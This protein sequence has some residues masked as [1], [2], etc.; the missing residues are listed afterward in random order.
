M[1]EKEPEN[2]LNRIRLALER[3]KASL[4][5]QGFFDDEYIGEF[6]QT[7]ETRT[8][9][10]LKDQY[11]VSLAEFGMLKMAA[12]EAEEMIRLNTQDNLGVRFTL[13]HLYAVLEDAESAETL[14]KQYSEHDESPMMLALTLLYYKLGETDK[15]EKALRR[16][17]RI[18]KETRKFVRDVL[19]DKLDRK[20]EAIQN[21]GGYSPFTE[22]EL[23][24]MYSENEDVY[25]SAPFFFR[26]VSKTLK[27]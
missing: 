3:G 6:W 12:R 19:T 1:E 26:W 24:M 16:L 2:L 22:E 14:L 8:F 5:S 9:M 27:M 4:E 25:H 17:T 10:R 7:F 15:A 20:L 13:M 23:I 21:Q 11:V 18:N